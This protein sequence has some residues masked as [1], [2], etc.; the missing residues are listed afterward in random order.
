VSGERQGEEERGA[1]G[2]DAADDKTAPLSFADLARTGPKR[3]GGER[4]MRAVMDVA[5]GVAAWAAWEALF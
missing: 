2:E 1:K 5:I 4:V 3:T